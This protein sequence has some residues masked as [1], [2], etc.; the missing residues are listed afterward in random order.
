MIAGGVGGIDC[1]ETKCNW[2]T[3][4]VD[5][6]VQYR[7]EIP[8]LMFHI[9][10]VTCEETLRV[11]A[12]TGYVSA[13]EEGTREDTVYVTETGIVYHKDSNCTYL[14]M[15]IRAVH[16]EKIEELRNHSGG[17]YY[18]CESCG[19]DKTDREVRYITDYGT[20]YHT[21]LEC[22]KIRRNVYA[23]SIDEAF[24]LGGC[25]KCVK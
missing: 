8:I 9:A 7:V 15:S 11:K 6:N 20:R 13:I 24:G 14:D 5:L 10:P 16:V 25:S 23:I 21:S 3:G 2:S 12:W 1:S 22:K 17:N 4:V 18:A 19:K